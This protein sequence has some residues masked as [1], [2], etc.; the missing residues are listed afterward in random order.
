M[1][2]EISAKAGANV[3]DELAAVEIGLKDLQPC[4]EDDI[5]AFNSFLAARKMPQ[6]TEGEKQRRQEFLTQALLRCTEVPLAAVQAIARLVPVARDLV[7]H[8]PDKVLSDLGVALAELDCALVGLSFTVSI[9]LRGT[10]SDPAFA[11]VRAQHQRLAAEISAAHRDLAAA[12][13]QV[14]Q[15]IGQT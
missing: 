1:V 10:D 15:K 8:A 4:V 3:D 13:D 6:L 12:I 9:N 7:G 11:A 5:K 2:L 14:A